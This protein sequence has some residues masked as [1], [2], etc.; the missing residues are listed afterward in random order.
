MTPRVI[1][2]NAPRIKPRQPIVQA[3]TP[4]QTTV[5]LTSSGFTSPKGYNHAA[6]R[7]QIALAIDP[8]FSAPVV[9]TGE[10]ASNLL[11][12]AASG[13]T[14]GVSYLA[15]A[16]YVDDSPFGAESSQWSH[17]ASFATTASSVQAATVFATE[18]STA[19]GSGDAAI[20]DTGRTRPWAVDALSGE[21]PEVR[22]TAGDGIDFPT[23][24]YLKLKAAAGD[25]RA[26]ELRFYQ[27][28]GYIP[29]LSPGDKVALRLYRQYLLPSNWGG[30]EELHGTY[31]GGPGFG[32]GPAVLG[33]YDQTQSSQ[34]TSWM[35]LS[36]GSDQHPSGPGRYYLPGGQPPTTFPFSLAHWWD[37]LWTL[38]SDNGSTATYSVQ[39]RL[40][41]ASDDTLLHETDEFLDRNG[42]GNH[43]GNTVFST[44]S[45]NIDSMREF[46]IGVNG[47]TPAPSISA[48]YMAVGGV[49]I[50]AGP[51][52]TFHGP[53]Q[54]AEAS[55]TP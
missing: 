29:A 7:W 53:Y 35:N 22:E 50:A 36:V 15:R 28:H 49:I 45:S 18:W 1:P 38:E 23:T 17:A 32:W 33:L 40:Y 9:D 46:R 43:L 10:S 13:L 4:G 51:D 24:N 21:A 48:D 6:T 52:A 42:D 31:F 19:L 14:Q 34:Q 25:G 55:W 41:D 44:S 30:D 8:G 16:Y 26:R 11:S 47:Y 27:S 3:G 5:T 39:A 54:A 20:R 12:Y 37:I 2:I